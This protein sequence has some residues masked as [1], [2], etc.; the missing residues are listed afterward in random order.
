M[1]GATSFDKTLYAFGYGSFMGYIHGAAMCHAMGIPLETYVEE[2]DRYPIMS[3]LRD[4][5]DMI[6]KR[7]YPGGEATLELEA[8]AY[9]HVVATSEALGIDTALAKLIEGF[10]ARSMADGHGENALAAMFETMLG[11]GG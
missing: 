2:M 5:G 4:A 9:R 3:M 8:A 1:G 6:V 11:N 10:F 7:N